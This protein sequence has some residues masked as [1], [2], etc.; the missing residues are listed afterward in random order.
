MQVSW[1]QSRRTGGEKE[2]KTVMKM[3]DLG[4]AKGDNHAWRFNFLYLVP[5]MVEPERN[6]AGLASRSLWTTSM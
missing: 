4:Y 3:T 2:G 5:F 6:K 1:R